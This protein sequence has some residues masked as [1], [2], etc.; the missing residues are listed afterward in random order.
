MLERSWLCRLKLVIAPGAS[1]VFCLVTANKVT[2]GQGLP[3]AGDT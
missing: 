3:K 1:A 2:D